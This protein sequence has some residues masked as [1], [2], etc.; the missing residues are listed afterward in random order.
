MDLFT[1]S[2][3]ESTGFINISEAALRL[4]DLEIKPDDCLKVTQWAEIC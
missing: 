1:I 2:K 4:E 3:P